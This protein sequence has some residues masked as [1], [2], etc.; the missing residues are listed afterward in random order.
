MNK[1]ITVNILMGTPYSRSRA[2]YSIEYYKLCLFVVAVA[3]P[4]CMSVD[5]LEWLGGLFEKPRAAQDNVM[6][7]QKPYPI[8]CCSHIIH[9]Q[10]RKTLNKL[11]MYN[12]YLHNMCVCARSCIFVY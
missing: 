9:T 1:P 11:N 3:L 2:V 7:L 5:Y 4:V 12:V 10:A 8:S 6:E